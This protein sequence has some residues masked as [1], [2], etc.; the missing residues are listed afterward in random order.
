[1]QFKTSDHVMIKYDDL[2][3]RTGSPIV[4]LSGIGANRVVF[5]PTVQALTAAGYRV[6]NID[7]R[8]QGESQRTGRG[9]RMSRHALDVQELMTALKLDRPVLIGNSMGASTIFALIS[10]V[11]QAHVRGVV[12]IDQTPKMIADQSWPFGFKELGWDSFPGYLR[13]PLGKATAHQINSTLFAGMKQQAAE[14]PYNPDTNYDLLVDHAFQDWR[15]IISELQIPL[16]VVAGGQSPYYDSDFAEVT[17]RLAEHGS[18]VVIPEAGHLVMAE[19]PEQFNQVLLD[20]LA[21]LAN[22]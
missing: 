18:S 10:L 11:G 21:Q 2:G 22:E 5:S 15:D 4:L 1:M 14:N 3:E 19:Q 20:F 8:N 7:A 6:I 9:Q 13:F 16:L 17:A 12:D